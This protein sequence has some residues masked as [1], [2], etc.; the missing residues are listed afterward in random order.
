MKKSTNRIWAALLCLLMIGAMLSLFA[1]SEE[2]PQPSCTAH[3][4]ANEDGK[5]DTCSAEV[6]LDV[7]DDHI[8]TDGDNL[9]EICGAVCVDPIA[10][11]I[12]LKDENGG[13]MKDI[14]LTLVFDGEEVLNTT[15]DAEGCVKAELLPGKY[16]VWFEGL[17]DG[18]Y[19]EGNMSEVEFSSDVLSH[20]F[21]AIDNNPD[22]SEEKP[23]YVGDEIV[24]LSMAPGETYHCFARG[25]STRYLVVEGSMAKIVYEGNEYLP[26]NGVI[27]V[28]VKGAEDTNSTM[29]F[30]VTN[31]GSTEGGVTIYFESLPGTQGKPY[32]AQADQTITIQVP[33]EDAVYY[34]YTATESGY[35]VLT[36]TSADNNIMMYNTTTYVVTS[37]T[38]GARC[39]YLPVNA[40]DTVSITVSSKGAAEVNT[41]EFSL[42][43][44]GDTVNDPLPLYGNTSMRIDGS[45]SL[46]LTW[47]GE[48]KTVS[49]DVSTGL[50]VTVNGTQVE[51]AGGSCIF[52]A[53][54]GDA[55]TITNTA[56]ERSDVVLFAS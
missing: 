22:G 10:V 3:T 51:A 2:V 47:M 48:E 24:E 56:Q 13:A 38:D 17:A 14:S 42:H 49:I 37:Y 4:D 39:L 29:P 33:A 28:L 15:T 26:E 50:T 27:R 54:Q 53:K 16:M 41:V 46:S 20:D 34:T 30:T 11:T 52:T 23:Y 40:G 18:W 55:I 12:T 25:T 21:T 19:V 5:C 1:C 6:E 44:H 35:L 8:D 45:A 32:Q 31:T 43:L 9:C 7:C 36:S